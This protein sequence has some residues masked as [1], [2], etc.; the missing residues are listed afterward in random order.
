MFCLSNYITNFYNSNH[1]LINSTGR[2]SL[3]FFSDNEV[4]F[5]FFKE[6]YS[7]ALRSDI[8]SEVYENSSSVIAVESK[9]QQSKNYTG[10]RGADLDPR[11]ISSALQSPSAWLRGLRDKPLVEGPFRGPL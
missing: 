3:I 9:L 2:P 11:S 7:N 10:T 5:K 4:L 1:D 8:V 6:R